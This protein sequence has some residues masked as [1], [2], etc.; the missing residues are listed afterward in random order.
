MYV[1]VNISVCVCVCERERDK[2]CEYVCVRVYCMCVVSGILIIIGKIG[3]I[4]EKNEKTS[5]G[6]D[7]LRF[8]TTIRKI[9][10]E[11]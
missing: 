5:S 7:D 9:C 6:R 4:V 3:K 10:V 8:R 2:T 11:F 1:C